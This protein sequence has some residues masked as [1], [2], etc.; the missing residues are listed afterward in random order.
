[1]AKA[2]L[3]IA[4]TGHRFGSSLPKQFHRLAGKKIYL[5]SLER[6]LE[7]A[8]WD[9]ILLVCY[10]KAIESV[11][12]E[13]AIYQAPIRLIA[14][15]KTRQES[16]FLGIKACGPGTDIVLIHDGVRPFVSIE[17]IQKNLHHA[18]QYGAVNTCIP[19]SDTPVCTHNS[20]ITSMPPRAHCWR[21]QTPQTFSYPLILRAHLQ[22]KQDNASDDCSLVM[23]LGEP[24]HVLEGSEENIKITTEMDLILAQQLLRFQKKK[25]FS[26]SPRSLLNQ[27]IALTGGTGDIG[28][29][30]GFLLEKE[31][32]LPLYISK[33]S[34]LFPCDLTDANQT[35]SLFQRLGPLDGLIN[36]I[37]FLKNQT[38]HALSREEIHQFIAI[39]LLAP[40][41]SC[42]FAQ[43]VPGGHLINIA[44]SAYFRGRKGLSLY[45]SAKAALVNFTQSLAEEREDL[46]VNVLVPFRTSGAMRKKDFPEENPSELLDPMEIARCAIALLQ[47]EQS[48]HLV[49]V[50]KK[51]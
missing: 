31:G 45:G 6:L 13:V 50:R 47:Q 39:N 18:A 14:G 22:T 25:A 35:E 19:S 8:S 11:R 30:I 28:R 20:R 42:R 40:L 9:E 26:L 16:S 24:I 44:S 23:E 5:Y 43:I 27:R 38:F 12:E 48:G 4:G 49:E 36:C 15:G 17:T 51:S 3:L 46:K 33:S 1:M 41:Y 21:G 32:A 7:A 2:I 34:D 37:G 10:Q 29:A